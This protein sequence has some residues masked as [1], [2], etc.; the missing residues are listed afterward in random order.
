MVQKDFMPLPLAGRQWGT[1]YF[2]SPGK[3]SCT[4]PI[5]V[6]TVI[7]AWAADDVED[8]NVGTIGWV[9]SKTTAQSITLSCAIPAYRF[10]YVVICQ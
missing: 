1:G 9:T 8:T 3:V 10:W 7:I 2:T 4:L 5:A 6:N